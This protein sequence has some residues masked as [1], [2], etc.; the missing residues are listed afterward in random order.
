M[1]PGGPNGADKNLG[2]I[3]SDVSEKASLLVRE[4]IELAKAEMA[5][6]AKKLARGTAS[7]AAAGVFVVFAI[8]MGL[9]S[10]A[11]LFYDIFDVPAWAAFAMVTL[12]LLL[13]ALIAGLVAARL[14]S[15]GAPPT[16]DMAI[17]QA[18]LTRDALEHHTGHDLPR[19]SPEQTKE[20]I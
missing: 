18:K 9:H 4:E 10:L 2:E 11:W 6:K 16:P 19:P 17:E 8:V 14:M 15:R 13:L 3:V 20:T 7:G 5:D 12:L 1:T